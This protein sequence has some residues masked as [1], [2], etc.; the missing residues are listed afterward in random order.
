MSFTWHRLLFLQILHKFTIARTAMIA[1][2]AEIAVLLPRFWFFNFGNYQILAILL[3][4]LGPIFRAP[5]LAVRDA[6]GIERA[7]HHVI[8][9][10]GEVLYAASADQHNRVLLQVVADA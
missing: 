1:I 6:C 2:I 7:A 9:D 10:A 8:A 3:G 4:P 5:L